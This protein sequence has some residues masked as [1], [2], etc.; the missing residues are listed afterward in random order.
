MP[1]PLDDA[2]LATAPP[3]ERDFSGVVIGSELAAIL[4][5]E[6]GDSATDLGSAVAEDLATVRPGLAELARLGS[7][8]LTSLDDTQALDAASRHREAAGLAG[9]AE[10]TAAQPAQLP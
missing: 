7:I 5:A 9:G 1:A 8:E 6:P 10:A 3:P 2:D 4:F